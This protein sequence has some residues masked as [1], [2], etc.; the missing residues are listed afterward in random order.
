MGFGKIWKGSRYV[1]V[2]LP[3]GKATPLHKCVVAEKL[4]VPKNW[5]IH[6]LK[7]KNNNKFKNLLPLPREI[8]EGVHK[9]DEKCLKKMEELKKIK[10]ND[11]KFFQK[12]MNEYK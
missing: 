12:I 8:H 6:H 5:D 10:N 2:T 7:S 1:M 11:L 3:N 4:N 9:N